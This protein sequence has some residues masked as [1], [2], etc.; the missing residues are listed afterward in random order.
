LEH[1]ALFEEKIWPMT[2]PL[3]SDFNVSHDAV[4]IA[5]TRLAI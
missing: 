2:G 5:I 1:S 3:F 4:K